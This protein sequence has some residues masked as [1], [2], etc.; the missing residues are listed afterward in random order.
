M[1]IHKDL[2]D[3]SIL[4]KY[5]E[6]RKRIW[7]EVIDP[8][9][10]ENFRRLHDQDPDKAH[11]ND[12]FFRTLILSEKDKGLARELALVSYHFQEVMPSDE[13]ILMFGRGWMS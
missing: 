11:E 1:G 6:V 13:V 8:M 4:D 5:A 3:D 12:E 9:S 7:A 2:A 10:R